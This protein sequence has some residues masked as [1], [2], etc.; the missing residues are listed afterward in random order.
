MIRSH[1]SRFFYLLAVLL[2]GNHPLPTRKPDPRLVLRP[3]LREADRPTI[4][5]SAS[6][7]WPAAN[8]NAAHTEAARWRAITLR[9]FDQCLTEILEKSEQEW[10]AR[11]FRERHQ[12]IVIVPTRAPGRAA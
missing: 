10:Q 12:P 4:R 7:T 11:K 8:D 2:A 1:L 6:P 5:T 9:T 3:I